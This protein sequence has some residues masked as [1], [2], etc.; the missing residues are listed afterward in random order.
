MNTED[1]VRDA[2][3]ARAERVEVAPDALPRIRERIE[4]HWW[5]GRRRWLPAIGGA[6]AVATAAAVVGVLTYQPKDGHPPTPANTAPSATTSAVPSPSAA[7]AGPPTSPSASADPLSGTLVAA[8]P[9]YYAGPGGKLFREYHQLKV[10]PDTVPGR[11]SAA[12]REMLRSKSAADPDYQT[13]WSGATVRGVQLDGATATVD[14]DRA[15]TTPAN[16]AQAVQQLVFT[17]AA[18]VADTP[19]PKVT[20]VRVTI[21]GAPAGQLWGVVDAT[22]VLRPGN[23]LDVLAP[24]WLIE[25]HEGAT[26]GQTFSVHIAGAVFEATGRLRVRDASGKVVKDQQV[27]LSIGA[28]QRGE[29][30]LKLTLAPGRYT[31][32]TYFLS[33]KDGTEQGLDGHRVTVR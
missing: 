3:A 18:A 11:V 31:I 32:E 21:G 5:H 1:R 4:R 15:G 20:G 19:L 6:V 33:A 12:V 2:L 24:L 13:L 8:I 10:T 9:V 22:G 27:M 29:A 25:P 17:V 23:A 7:P 28:P 14:L 26:V 30:T 16:P